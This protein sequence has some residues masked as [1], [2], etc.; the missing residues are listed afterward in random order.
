MLN[1]EHDKEQLSGFDSVTGYFRFFEIWR[2]AVMDAN[3]VGLIRNIHM[4]CFLSSWLL[5]EI[6][7]EFCENV[8]HVDNILRCPEIVFFLRFRYSSIRLRIHRWVEVPVD[9]PTRRMA[10]RYLQIGEEDLYK[11]A[12]CSHF[13]GHPC[14]T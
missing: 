13:H 14:G 2:I 1:G 9:Y 10:Y 3:V 4:V 6:V 7:F 5:S 11:I 12:K 8:E